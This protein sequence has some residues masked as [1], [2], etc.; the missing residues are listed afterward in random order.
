MPRTEETE[1]PAIFN[2][3]AHRYKTRINRQHLP[4]GFCSRR[5]NVRST[6]RSGNTSTAFSSV[7]SSHNCQESA[8]HHSATLLHAILQTADKCWDIAAANQLHDKF[9]H[10]STCAVGTIRTSGS[11]ISNDVSHFYD[12]KKFSGRNFLVN[13]RQFHHHQQQHRP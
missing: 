10:V 9:I 7:S 5:I 4:R 1:P 12:L 3:V 2:P 6:R 13:P 8:N 11:S